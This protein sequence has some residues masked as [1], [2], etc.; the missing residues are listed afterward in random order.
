MIFLFTLNIS[1]GPLSI[2]VS[3]DRFGERGPRSR[4]KHRVARPSLDGH[5]RDCSQ[6]QRGLFP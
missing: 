4:I 1:T 6:I 3:L 5:R 2:P